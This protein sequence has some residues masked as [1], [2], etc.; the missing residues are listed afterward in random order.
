LAVL[1]VGHLTLTKN[2]IEA[3]IQAT[4]AGLPP[5]TAL[6]N[7]RGERGHLFPPECKHKSHPTQ[8]PHKPL[9][10][11]HPSKAETKGKKKFDLEGWEKDISKTIS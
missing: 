2:K 4:E 3:Q 8:S 6:P 11:P 9:D 5:H 1:R 7:R 10:Q